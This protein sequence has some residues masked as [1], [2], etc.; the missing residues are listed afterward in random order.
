MRQRWE[1]LTSIDHE[2]RYADKWTT[3]IS[4][5]NIHNTYPLTGQIDDESQRREISV[6]RV[7]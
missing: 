5:A 1:T 2:E 4:H 6:L 3:V 7:V